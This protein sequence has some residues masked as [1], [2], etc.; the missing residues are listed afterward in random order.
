MNLNKNCASFSFSWWPHLLWVPLNSTHTD[1]IEVVQYSS[2]KY[3]TGNSIAVQWLR[4][5]TV[6][7]VAPGSIPDQ[8]TKIPQTTQHGQKKEKKGGGRKLFTSEL[9]MWPGDSSKMVLGGAIPSRQKHSVST[10]MLACEAKLKME[11]LNRDIL[12]TS[13][14]GVVGWGWGHV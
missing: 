14:C 1:T 10:Q 13:T 9:F 7:A 3:L 2:S 12:W 11:S 4:L 5:G 6:T 8:R